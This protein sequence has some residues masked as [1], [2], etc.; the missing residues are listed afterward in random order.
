MSVDPNHLS[1][2]VQR[3]QRELQESQDRLQAATQ[4][5]GAVFG[6]VECSL[7]VDGVLMVER[8]GGIASHLLGFDCGAFC[9]QPLSALLPTIVASPLHQSLMDIA[10]QGGTVS[11]QSVPELGLFQGRALHCFAFQS[12]PRG[13]VLKIWDQGASLE[14]ASARLGTQQQ[15]ATLFS[16]NPNAM[17]LI[18]ASD[19]TFVDV[20]A[21]WMQL[22]GLP[23]KDVLGRRP[24]TLGFWAG[25]RHRDT[26]FQSLRE[27]GQLRNIDVP[28]ARSDGHTLILQVNASRIEVAGV[29]FVLSSYKDVSAE[30]LAQAELLASE[31]L[32][33]ATNKRL[34]Q[35]IRMFEY[36]EDLAAV[37]HWTS[38]A[39]P[40]S[41]QW[42]TGL[43]RI[44][45][46][47]PGTPLAS[48]AGF[49]RIHEQD[50]PVFEEARSKLD[51]SIVE[52]RRLHRDGRVHWLR[53][54]MRRWAV[55]GEEPFDFGMVQD[56][57]SEKEAAQALQEKLEFIKK[58]TSRL[59][60]IVFQFRAKRDG[61][62]EFP[63]VSQAASELFPGCS[64]EQMMADARCTFSLHHPDDLAV[65]LASVKQ[66]ARDLSPW[67]HEY[68]LRL[69]DGEVRWLLGQAIPEREEDGSILWN[70]FSSDI[71]ERKAAEQRLRDSESRFRALTQLSSDWYWEQDAEYR[72]VSAYG[73]LEAA[74]LSAGNAYMGKTRWESGAEGVSSEGWAAH[75]AAVEAHEVFHDFQMQR[76]RQD[77]SLMWVSIS[78]A[79][80]FD[81]D[82]TF[83]GYRGIGRDISARRMAE[84]KIER[85]AFFDA[86]TGL[87][88]RRLLMDRLQHA[89]ALTEREGQTGAL[90]FIDLD[91]FK[92]LN[93]TRGH[94]MGDQLLKQ[95]AIRLHECV[96]DADTVARLGGDEFVV[97]LQKLSSDQDDAA[98]HA[99]AV[100]RKILA[101]LN[102]SYRLSGS[103]FHS[104]PSIG[105]A[106]FHDNKLSVDELLKRADL[107]MYQA[108]AAGRNTAR[109]FDPVMQAAASARAAIEADLRVALSNREFVLYFQPVVNEL[110]QTIGVEALVRWLHP[111][112]GLVAPGEF[113]PVAEQTGLILQLGHWVLE[114]A[115]AQLVVWSEHA[116][117]RRL[118]MA[119]NVSAR[120]FRH[121]DFSNQILTLLRMTGAN[122]YRLK[123]ELTETLLLTDFDDVIAKMSELRSI[124]VSFSLDD[125]GTGYSSLSYL[126]QLPLDQLKIDKSFV[127]DVL[128]D[129]N[130]AAIARTVL[131]LAAS[132][133]LGV[134]AEGVETA[135]QRDF[136]LASGCKAFQGYFFGKPTPLEQLRLETAPDRFG[137]LHQSV[138]R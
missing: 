130:D 56:I 131:A 13:V 128:T 72:F 84:D 36:M 105:I 122:P 94:D 93:D 137:L 52:Y 64:A 50:R 45:G 108:K 103:D 86:L 54:R 129:P 123:L 87:P 9:Q 3:L 112:H 132:L 120:Q 115:C 60:G 119:V 18:S 34:S 20:N 43:Y 127:R 58:I 29:Q 51:G 113:I 106:L 121:P 25:E 28:F 8:V 4:L 37:G 117:T 116:D 107:A 15:L 90:L 53:S 27:K 12:G 22:T 83:T 62:F 81:Q 133:D 110:S 63:F 7:A 48:P 68:R 70:G 46:L 2:E 97:M 1:H 31:Q 77:G 32:L 95:V 24:E 91:N 118:T 67:N 124:G 55:E 71:T 21:E 10:A 76:R 125:F 73:D 135:G 102:Q 96:R 79:P 92:D 114:Q 82:G 99:E 16:E 38:G 11:P 138:R 65:L 66:S 136:L 17:A 41:L 40:S 44:S 75:R 23:L 100:G 39:D 74:S 109:F 78:G 47:E 26:G 49:K 59:P 6:S 98:T 104:T 89:L 134:V 33:K 61:G 5:S 101:T 19:G 35:Q 126:K 30:R 57:T 85:L 14:A 42:S 69:P 111:R 88:N 80:I